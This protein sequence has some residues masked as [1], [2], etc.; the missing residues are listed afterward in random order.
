MSIKIEDL[1]ISQKI[2]GDG[3]RGLEEFKIIQLIRLLHGDY[4]ITAESTFDNR[5]S[6]FNLEN[7]ALT[8]PKQ[9]KRYWLWDVTCGTS[10]AIFKTNYY[11]DDCRCRV[12]DTS[13]TNQIDLTLIK[14]HENEFID[15]E[16]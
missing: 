16:E 11:M 3:G 6:T 14:K 13:D 8:P 10:R 12:G 4:R 2:Y 9:K 15:I 7:I 1:K 5:I